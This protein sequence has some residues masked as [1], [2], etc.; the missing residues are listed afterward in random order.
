VSTEQ[1]QRQAVRRSSAPM[2]VGDVLARYLRSSGLK[3]KLRSPEIYDGWPEVA[4]AEAVK[5]TRVA[6]FTNGVLHVEVDSAPWLQRLAAFQKPDLLRRLRLQLSGVRVRDIQF[7][8]GN[9]EQAPYAAIERKL[10][11]KKHQRPPTTRA[12]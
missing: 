2:P 7:R 3:D 11:P 5:H 6:G 1:V 4:G 10:C 12:T 9:T 8:I